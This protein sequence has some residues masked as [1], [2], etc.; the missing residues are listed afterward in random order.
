VILL[1]VP[2]RVLAFVGKELVEV[3]RRPGAIASL[4]IGPLIILAI[5]GAGYSGTG[6][7]LRTILVVP[8]GSGLP[9]EASEY[10]ALNTPGLELAEITTDG[11]TA[12]TAL[13]DGR[14]D[15]VV[16]AP[17]D[18]KAAIREGRRSEIVVAWNLIDPV[19]EAFATFYAERL[20]SEVNREI[21]ERAA[22]EGQTWAVEAGEAA[23]AKIPPDVVASPAKVS[24]RNVSPTATS[25]TAFYSPAVLALILQHMALSLVAISL[26]RE[27]STG[28]FELFRISPVSAAEVIAGKVVAFMLLC[29]AVAAS[30][31]ALL[32]NVLHVPLLGDPAW[33]VGV[34]ALVILASLG[35]GM[36]VA[37]VADSERQAVQLALLV[38]LASVFFSGLVISIEQFLP[39]VR[40]LAYALPVTHGVRLMQDLMLRGS[41]HAVWEVGALGA[42]A[43]V[44]LLGAWLLLRVR[45]RRA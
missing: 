44:S 37:L 11:A 18:A 15:I 41:T 36:I 43:V 7:S 14:V 24:T 38:L 39:A 10:A 33:L 20:E 30:T 9:T 35:L 45:M 1:Q 23:A 34:V 28:I 13:V 27:R 8:P 2:T 19:Q 12:E 3:V 26:V 21:I 42:I 40:V 32:V 4:V 25:V 6:R 17:A 31:V 5:F 16:F 22:D 29:G